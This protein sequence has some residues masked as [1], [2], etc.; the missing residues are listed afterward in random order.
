MHDTK[1][2][3]CCID[4]PPTRLG[5]IVKKKLWI[6][7]RKVIKVA[8]VNNSNVDEKDKTYAKNHEYEKVDRNTEGIWKVLSDAKKSV[9]MKTRHL[10]Q[11]QQDIRDKEA[12]VDQKKQQDIKT[13][14]C[15]EGHPGTGE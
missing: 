8:A 3:H 5:K 2:D 13:L 6:S 4:P 9:G 1:Q 14:T 15:R 12:V 11:V 7:N 10:D